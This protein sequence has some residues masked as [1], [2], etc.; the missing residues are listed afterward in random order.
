MKKRMKQLAMFPKDKHDQPVMVHFTK[1]QAD[2][3][4]RRARAEMVSLGAVVRFLVAQAAKQ[5][6]VSTRDTTKGTP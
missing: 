1:A 5:L 3:L 6:P 4:R 2:W